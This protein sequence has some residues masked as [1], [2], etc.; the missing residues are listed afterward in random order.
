MFGYILP[1]KG[2]MKIKE[3]ELFRAYYCGVCKS[4]GKSFGP[5]CRFALN[6]DSVFLGMLLSSINKESVSLK[7][8]PCIAN[9]L[10]RKWVVKNSNSVDFSA[11]INIILTYYKF[12][13]DWTD[14]KSYLAKLGQIVISPGYKRA[15]NCSKEAESHIKKSLEKLHALESQR[16]SSMDIAADPFGELI[17]GIISIGCNWDN[18]KKKEAVEWLGYNI[19]KWIYIIDA[20]D[21]IEKDIEKNSYNP[22]LLQYTYKDEE[23]NEFKNRIR[24]EVRFNL[25]H[26]LAQAASAFELLDMNN[27]SIIENI[28]YL[29]M[30]KKTKS[31]LEGRS[32]NKDEKSL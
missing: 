20:F 24:D 15:L 16:C 22:L 1:D 11:D 27:K 3:Y 2:E 32:C 19:G 6:Y 10:K 25:I 26:T 23:V 8:E 21:D 9:P 12:K 31:V 13:D 30:D 29:G 14:E 4:M 18:D 17:K 5:L 28:L 7:K